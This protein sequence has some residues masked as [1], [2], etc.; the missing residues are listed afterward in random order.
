MD[1]EF[2]ERVFP[3]LK[4]VVSSNVTNLGMRKQKR[5]DSDFQWMHPPRTHRFLGFCPPGD[6]RCSIG[7]TPNQIG[8][9]DTRPIASEILVKGLFDSDVQRD[10]VRSSLT[11]LQEAIEVQRSLDRETVWQCPIHWGWQL[12]RASVVT[13]GPFHRG[14]A[15]AHLLPGAVV[16]LALSRH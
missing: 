16:A 2:L 9:E 6:R 10:S 8:S 13:Q 14:R 3:E 4:R 1:T 12:S 5:N 15:T 7:D 11:S